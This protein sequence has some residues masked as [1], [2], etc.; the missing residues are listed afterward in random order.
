MLYA[1]CYS[2][3]HLI[4]TRQKCHDLLAATEFSCWWKGLYT[5]YVIQHSWPMFRFSAQMLHIF[6]H[7]VCHKSRRNFNKITIILLYFFKNTNAARHFVKQ[8][9]TRERCYDVN[10]RFRQRDTRTMP[11]DLNHVTREAF[12]RKLDTTNVPSYRYILCLRYQQTEDRHASFVREMTDILFLLKSQWS[13]S[14]K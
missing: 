4:C 13:N 1:F 11:S 10:P 8:W 12:L 2:G 7:L 3:E 9:S 6:T 5:N 14:V